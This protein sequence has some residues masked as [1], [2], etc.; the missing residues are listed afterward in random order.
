MKEKVRAKGGAPSSI[1]DRLA[2]LELE[3]AQLKTA[4]E[5]R[6]LVEQAKG[7]ISVRFGLAPD[8]AFEMMR[9]LARSQHREIH[10]YAAEIVANGGRFAGGN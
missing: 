6:I 5:S 7:A 1:F 4:L 10:E 2:A 9:S 3:N 8:E